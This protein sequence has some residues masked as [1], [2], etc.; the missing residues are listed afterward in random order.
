MKSKSE[1]I[2]DTYGK[3]LRVRVCG[4]CFEGDK[5]LLV[6]HT[7]LTEGLF[8]APP[9]GG[10]EF[11]ENAECCLIREF[12]EETGLQIEVGEFLFVHEFNAPPLHAIELF[13]SVHAKGGKLIT[14]SDPEMAAEHQIIESVAF[15]SPQEI[16]NCSDASLHHVLR[17]CRQP[18]DLLEMQGYFKYEHKTLK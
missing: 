10:M 12:E 13:F 14:G 3:R 9:G 18:A 16:Q 8:Y 11:G 1:I 2:S 17:L 5:L 4:L 7:S 15:M 6:R